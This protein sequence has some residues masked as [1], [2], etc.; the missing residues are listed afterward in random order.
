MVE[1]VNMN[2]RSSNFQSITVNQKNIYFPVLDYRDLILFALGTYQIRQ[3][4]SYYGEQVGFHGGC[5]I[6]VCN[7]IN[8]N[9][10]E[11]N[12]LRGS[13][14]TILIRGKIKSHHVS[15]R[16]YY[17]ILYLLVENNV[18][19]RA[20]IVEYCCSCLVGRRTI[21]CCAHSMTLVWYLGWARHQQNITAP[22]GFLGDIV[23][24][25]DEEYT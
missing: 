4:R 9:A 25:D 22:A 5:R 7:E 14:D 10:S 17:I 24:R 15:R 19:S 11:Y 21:G 3:A 23:I 1:A 13:E 12:N 6:E 8:I 18:P 16:Q 20:G 2:R